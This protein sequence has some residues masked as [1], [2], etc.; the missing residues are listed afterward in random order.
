MRV[1]LCLKEDNP[2]RWDWVLFRG[3]I[4]KDKGVCYELIEVF[5][6]TIRSLKNRELRKDNKT[7]KL[8][9]FN[10]PGLASETLHYLPVMLMGAA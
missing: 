2:I 3:W 9:T 6:I 10:Q 1:Q 7:R 5:S 4:R 8:K